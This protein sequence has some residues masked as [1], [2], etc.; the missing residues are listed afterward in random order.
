MRG[1]LRNRNLARRQT[2]PVHDL[3]R[4]GFGVHFSLAWVASPELSQTVN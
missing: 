1:P 3:A 4:Y 2:Q